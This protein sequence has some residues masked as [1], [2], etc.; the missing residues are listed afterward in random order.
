MKLPSKFA[1]AADRN[2][3]N[4]A[5]SRGFEVSTA[6]DGGTFID[7]LTKGTVYKVSQSGTVSSKPKVLARLRFD[8]ILEAAKNF[9]S[10]KITMLVRAMER[11]LQLQVQSQLQPIPV[12]AKRKQ[13]LRKRTDF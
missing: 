3:H 1:K 9:A 5:R 2:A 6:P 11:Q 10:P 12:R 7:L 4:L 13:Q 8:E